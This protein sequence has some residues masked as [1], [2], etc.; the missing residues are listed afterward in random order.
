MK[1]EYKA[2]AEVFG[3]TASDSHDFNNTAAVA[4][5]CDQATCD[6]VQKNWSGHE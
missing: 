6:R 1:R 5:F 2:L 3:W 4:A